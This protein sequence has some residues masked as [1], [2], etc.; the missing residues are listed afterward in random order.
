MKVKYVLEYPM[1]CSTLLL[2]PRISTPG[3]LSEW[4]ADNVVVE[5][6]YFVFYWDG[7]RQKAEVKLKKDN[8]YMRF[9][10]VDDED[11][12]TFFEFRILIDELTND[13]ALVVTDFVEEGEKIDAIDLWNSQLSVLKHCV[14][15]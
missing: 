15:V 7:T 6:K 5:G 14:G 4:F 2:Y 11:E 9:H 8:A 12:S 3:G 13:L 1:N 10:W